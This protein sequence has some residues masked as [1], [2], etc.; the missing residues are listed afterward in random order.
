MSVKSVG[1]PVIWDEESVTGSLEVMLVLI[2]CCHCLQSQC[3]Y[4]YNCLHFTYKHKREHN[5]NITNNINVH[6]DVL[7]ST[8][9]TI[10]QIDYWHFRGI[11]C[12]SFVMSYKC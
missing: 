3:V 5:T 6:L 4:G 9:F 2:R 11:I 8:Q 7:E 1:P 12:V 10:F